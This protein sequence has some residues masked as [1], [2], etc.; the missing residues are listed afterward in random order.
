MRAVPARS[1]AALVL[2]VALAAYA[3]PPKSPAAT[4]G[5]R[6]ASSVLSVSMYCEFGYCEATAS[7][8]SGNYTWTWQN[9]NPDNTT[10]TISTA[11]PCWTYNGQIV[12]VKATVSDGS[13]TASASRRYTCSY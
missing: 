10:G 6:A 8:G 4:A 2:S 9:A 3:N 11:T 13:T 12:T 1:L 7:G 5:P